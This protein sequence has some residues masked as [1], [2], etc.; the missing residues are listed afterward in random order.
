MSPLT[1]AILALRAPPG[2]T[3]TFPAPA[4]PVQDA[5]DAQDVA[6]DKGSGWQI[7][8]LRK[9]HRFLFPARYPKPGS[10][11]LSPAG[12]RHRREGEGMGAES[13]P[14]ETPKTSCL[15]LCL[16]LAV[17]CGVPGAGRAWDSQ[18]RWD[19]EIWELEEGEGKR[20]KSER[21]AGSNIFPRS[22]RGQTSSVPPRPSPLGGERRHLLNIH[23]Q[24]RWKGAAAEGISAAAAAM[25]A[26]PPPPRPHG[27]LGAGTKPRQTPP[28]WVTVSSV[29]CQQTARDAKRSRDRG[30]AAGTWRQH[31]QGLPGYSGWSQ[32]CLPAGNSAQQRGESDADKIRASGS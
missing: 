24:P 13:L 19:W 16:Q 17:S 2:N 11:F 5:G 3:P 31:F 1:P 12:A 7:G 10:D 26:S 22:S 25:A 29:P 4:P 9:R 6:Q 8:A 32:Q 27:G 28:G 23:S 21:Q 30:G 15:R 20:Q 14:G 18:R